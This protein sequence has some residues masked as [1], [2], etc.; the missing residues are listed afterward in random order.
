MKQFIEKH[1]ANITGTWRVC[2][3]MGLARRRCQETPWI[4][5]MRERA[6]PIFSQTLCPHRSRPQHHD[7]FNPSQQS[8]YGKTQKTRRLKIFGWR[9]DFER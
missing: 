5:N 2:E 3:K 4:N 9:K 6:C 7:G 8:E 1:A